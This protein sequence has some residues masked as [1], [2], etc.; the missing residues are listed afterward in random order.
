MSHYER[1]AYGADLTY[2]DKVIALTSDINSIYR[3]ALDKYPNQFRY[4]IWLR[5]SSLGP[6]GSK[7][8]GGKVC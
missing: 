8:G 4:V 3:E 5:T 6:S 1:V 2:G 7:Q